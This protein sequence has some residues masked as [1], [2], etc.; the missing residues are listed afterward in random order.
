A[1]IFYPPDGSSISPGLTSGAVTMKITSSTSITSMYGTTLIWFID[2]RARRMILALPLQDV[3]ELLDER[4]V[5]HRET[6][7][8]VCVAVVRAD[9]RDRGEEADRGGDQRFGDPRRDVRERRL[10]HV[11]EAAERIHDAPH[12]AEEADV[13]RHRA[14]GRE[15]RQV[16]VERVDLALV[17][18][19]HRAARAVHRDRGVA[20]LAPV[21][22]VLA[23]AG[24]EDVLEAASRE[25]L[26]RAL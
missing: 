1:V 7:G 11:R 4:L 24:G 16:R 23:E 19:A 10:A 18:G 9:P 3:R 26:A 6:V 17:G 22:R 2:L 21:L 20:A 14:D 13:G 8:V 12:G 5:A 15:P 25:R